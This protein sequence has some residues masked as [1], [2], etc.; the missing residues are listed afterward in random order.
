MASTPRQRSA[1]S[2]PVAGT[3]REET[4]GSVFE[5]R[6]GRLEFSEGALVRLRVPVAAPGAD[7]G[8][9]VLTDVDV[10]TVDVD[11][12][13]RITRSS[14]E[15]K[16]GRGQSGEP[17]TIVWLAGL[18]QLLRLS[19]VTFARSAVSSRARILARR[20]NIPTLDEPQLMA[21]EK[22]ISWLP[23]RF[24]HLDG[25]ECVA[26][27]SRTDAQLRGLPGLP[28]EITQFLRN[29]ALFADSSRLLAGI[30]SLG[31]GV[32]AQGVLP[33][34]AGA[35]L[36][37]HALIATILA[38][39][40]DA[41]R[42]GEL[43]RAD[44]RRRLERTL[45][46]GDA[47]DGYFLPLLERA[48]A[49]MQ[50]SIERVHRLYVEQGAEPVDVDVPS[51]REIIATPPDYLDDYLDLVERLRS[52]TS[53]ARDLLQTAE[54]A[55]F[56]FALGG[57]AWQSP[58]FAHLLTGEHRGFLLVALRTLTRIAGEQVGATLASLHQLPVS[59]VAVPDRRGANKWSG[60][61]PAQPHISGS[62]QDRQP[63]GGETLPG[64]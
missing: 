49:L 47:E 32:R 37:G 6:I 61:T 10:L 2:G 39:L 56:D 22:A 60:H 1:R 59:T 64:L 52:N 21:R 19:R 8:R 48:D 42:L 45:V 58:A 57:R 40:Q 25:A 46:S 12:R 18:R 50:Y 41:G 3:A 26:A 24:A 31:R 44:L 5:R 4:D 51:L 11:L 20:L 63:E 36:A 30:D 33:E 62:P 9:E 15:A 16:T 13:L 7:R 29:E 23:D 54:I 38:A 53:V 17:V 27:E 28:S 35:V 34:P 55:C 14:V 43:S